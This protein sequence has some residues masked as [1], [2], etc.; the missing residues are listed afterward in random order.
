MN[1][2]RTHWLPSEMP[3]SL[4]VPFSSSQPSRSQYLSLLQ[5]K[6]DEQIKADLKDARQAMEMSQESAPELWSIAEQNPLSQ[7]AS[8][9]VKSDRLNSLLPNPWGGEQVEPEQ[10]SLR[11]MLEQLA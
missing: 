11:E 3:M 1:D 10:T 8:A 6:L 5:A 2:S 4:S 9:L 7:W